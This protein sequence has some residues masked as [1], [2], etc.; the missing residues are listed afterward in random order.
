MLAS[1]DFTATPQQSALLKYVVKQTLAGN[2]SE[3]KGYTVATEVFGRRSDFD[4]SIDPIVSIQASRLRSALERYYETGGKNEPIRI[5]IPSGGYVPTFI[6][7]R[8]DDQHLA[9]EQDASVNVMQ[10][11]PAVLLRPL[12]KLTDNP[13]DNNFTIGI[14]A[15]LAHALSHYQEIRVLE[16]LHRDQ[17]STSPETDID[18][19]IEGNVRRDSGGLKVAIRLIDAKNGYQ[20]WSGKYH[21][22][23]EAAKMILFQEE[24]AGEIAV[25]LAG[26]NAVISRHLADRSGNKVTP[27]LTTYE[28]MLRYW[29]CDTMRTRQ[30]YVRAIEALRHAVDQQPEYGQ[31]WSMLATQYADNYG[32]ELLDLST[33]LEKAA[34]FAQ[35]GV[36]LEPANRRV[37]MILAHVRL[38][39]N[40]LQ[41]ARC[42]AETAYNLCPNSLMVLDTIGWVMALA[43]DWARGVD[44]IKKAIK[45]NPYYRPWVRHALWLNWF[46]LGNYEM[47]YRETHHFMMPK[48]FWEPLMKA[49][50]CGHLGRIEE[51]QACGRALLALKPDFAQRGRILI[52]RYVKFEDIVERVIEGLNAVGTEVR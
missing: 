33:P 46:R 34:E 7:Q 9:A 45:L 21:G 20:L 24:V 15:E 23:L 40:R 39:E 41:E 18:F 25:C 42:E 14:T 17:K 52:G 49:A 28:A 47:A 11:W 3:I 43:G 50:A 19:I 27:D 35:K 16:A 1:P 36:S 38:M 8:P 44:W 22:D 12:A 2:A 32:L 30:S 48:L 37:R 10:T 4:Q 13:E 5:D 51:G 29:V 26:D 6:K 31:T